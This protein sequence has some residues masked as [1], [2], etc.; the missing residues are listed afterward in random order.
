MNRT[1]LENLAKFIESKTKPL[2]ISFRIDDDIIFAVGA[3]TN[4]TVRLCYI[5][6]IRKF[7]IDIRNS[8]ELAKSIVVN[9]IDTFIH[10]INTRSMPAR[11][12][13]KSFMLKELKDRR[14]FIFDY[15]SLVEYNRM[16]S[17]RRV[18][19][20]KDVKLNGPAT[21]IFWADN[22]KTVVKCG[23]EDD[24]DLEKGI[25]MAIAKKALGNKGNYYNEIRKCIDK[26]PVITLQEAET[27]SLVRCVDSIKDRFEECL[28]ER[29]ESMD[30]FN[31]STSR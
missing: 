22:T 26:V 28:K 7:Q 17:S 2:D 15:H 8:L 13:G 1:D 29:L 10:D 3:P 20:I 6:L 5:D 21:I 16:S 19:L 27:D 12:N 23:D 9:E 18:P 4:F 30:H 14:D 31:T 24:Y 11:R 25:A